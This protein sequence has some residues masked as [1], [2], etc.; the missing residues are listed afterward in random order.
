MRVTRSYS[1]S[2]GATNYQKPIPQRVALLIKQQCCSCGACR[3]LHG[4]VFLSN[5]FRLIEARNYRRQWG[6]LLQGAH[7]SDRPEPSARGGLAGKEVLQTK[8]MLLPAIS[9]TY[10]GGR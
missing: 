6:D 10:L 5:A 7:C 2:S 9:A 3:S 8:P 4:L 1:R